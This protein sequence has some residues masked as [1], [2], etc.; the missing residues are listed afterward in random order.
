M[1]PPKNEIEI[2]AK[3]VHS[4]LVVVAKKVAEEFG[5]I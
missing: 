5:E 1:A 3:E 4:G 2:L